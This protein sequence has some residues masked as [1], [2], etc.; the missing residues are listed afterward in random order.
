MKEFEH[1]II[2]ELLEMSTLKNI[3]LSHTVGIES[4]EY[5]GAGYFLTIKV[6]GL[7]KHRVV[8][9]SPDIRGSLGSIEVGFIGFIE[10]SELTLE[11]YSYDQEVLPEHRDQEFTRNAT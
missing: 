7:P 1:K 8:L 5:S 3:D 10:K 11:C 4:I 6:K 2:V 9:D